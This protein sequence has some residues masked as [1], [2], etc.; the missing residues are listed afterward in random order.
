[1]QHLSRRAGEYHLPAKSSCFG[2]YVDNIVRLTHHLLIVLYHN[3]GVAHIAQF[4]ERVNQSVVV[5]LVQTD[6]RLVENIKY[7]DQS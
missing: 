2:A 5:P 6:T 3:D 4:F 1:M 7:I